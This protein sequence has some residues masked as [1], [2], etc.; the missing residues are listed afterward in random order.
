M[1]MAEKIATARRLVPVPRRQLR[2]LANG[3]RRAV[4]ATVLGHL[5]RCLFL[6]RGQVN[7]RGFCKA[8]WIADVF[9]VGVRNVKDA[10]RHLEQI[11]V[12][13]PVATPQWRMNRLGKC[14][15]INLGWSRTAGEREKR[16][17]RSAPPRAVFTTRSAPPESN[18]ELLTELKNQNPATRGRSGVCERGERNPRSPVLSNIVPDDLRSV[19]RLL[20]LFR[21]AVKARLAVP[22]E[23][24]R[25]QFVAAAEHARAIG[26]RNPC[27]LFAAIVRRK[28]WHV[29]TQ[30]D[31]DA[32]LSKLKEL[33]E[34]TL[35]RAST[36]SGAAALTSVK[37]ILESSLGDLSLCGFRP[38]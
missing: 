35:M 21:Q 9:N 18:K 10:R 11:G 7:A 1:E 25:I 37:S 19:G 6:K 15:A 24:A 29:I 38:C 34:R 2:F 14:L 26:T 16:N 32:A 27:G 17:T 4:V 22:S 5:M 12:L 13:L 31:E 33:Q 36:H 8:S 30:H 28:L 3:A 20:A 23:H